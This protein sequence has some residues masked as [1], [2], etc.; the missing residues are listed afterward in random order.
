MYKLRV[1]NPDRMMVAKQASR[2]ALARGLGLRSA[3]S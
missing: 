1:P 3:P 2:A